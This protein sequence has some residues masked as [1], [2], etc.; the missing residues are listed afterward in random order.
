MA[1]VQRKEQEKKAKKNSRNKR[2][3]SKTNYGRAILTAFGLVNRTLSRAASI[4]RPV[5]K[6]EEVEPSGPE[7][8]SLLIVG[9]GPGEADVQAGAPFAGISGRFL[10]DVLASLGADAGKIR[11]D[12]I[13][14][15]RR[16]KLEA[17]EVEEEGH[18]RAV[19]A[20][21]LPGSKAVLL[22]GQTAIKGF[23]GRT[24]GLRGK[25]LI[26]TRPDS[27]KKLVVFPTFHPALI[28]RTG[29][30]G[31]R[32]YRAWIEH[33]KRALRFVK[34]IP[35][36]SGLESQA[37]EETIKLLAKGGPG[38]GFFGHVGR[39]GE[40]GGSAPAE[41]AAK[42]SEAKKPKPAPSERPRRYGL[43]PDK[44]ADRDGVDDESRVGVPADKVPPPPTIPRLPNLTDKEREIEDR[45][46]KAFEEDPDALVR[47]YREKLAKGEIGDAPNIYNT[48]DAKLLS[49]D[50]NPQ[51]VSEEEL[52]AARAENNI[53]VH[54]TAN[55][56]AKRAFLERLD[57]LEKLPPDQRTVLVTSGGVAAGK[58]YA[59]G[60]VPQAQEIASK[61]GAVW[62]AAG[63]QN[64]T[65][66]PWI[67]KECERRGI[68]PIFAFVHA[69]PVETWENPQRGVIERANKKGRMVDAELFADSYARGAKN[70]DAFQRRNKDKADF[71]VI[72]NRGTPKLLDSVPQ[73]ALELRSEAIRDRALK[74]LSASKAKPYVKA[75]GSIGT[76]VFRA[77][78]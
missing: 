33:L 13:F 25:T 45:F 62:D 51:G 39:P 40:R 76:R 78:S 50:Y 28:V 10:R 1:R 41:G 54:Q 21:E 71:I 74:A 68:R 19:E 30:K 31:S 47:A 58:G 64:A 65:E 52:K 60:K 27:D 14:R 34:L 32:N 4:L 72:D 6:A 70:F 48:D 29:R 2:T 56:V 53:L 9:D 77:A 8:A 46:A 26:V 38:S 37:I 66:N 15:N 5:R 36:D 20:F 35:G 23:L 42:P 44:D 73:E 16:E 57:E 11:F 3:P 55:A 61:V 24:A 7:S 17:D 75:G 69:D 18:E 59:L 63:E 12:N 43:N 67:L 22:M 49:P